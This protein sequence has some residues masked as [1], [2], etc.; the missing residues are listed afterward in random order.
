MHKIFYKDILSSVFVSKLVWSKQ[1]AEQFLAATRSYEAQTYFSH[2]HCSPT[3][4]I[5]IAHY[6][7][8]ATGTDPFTMTIN[9]FWVVPCGPKLQIMLFFHLIVQLCL[10]QIEAD[11]YIFTYS[12]EGPYCVKV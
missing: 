12:P 7:Y 4:G 3:D 8:R 1:F 6:A 5:S 2:T 9:D 11:R 10:S